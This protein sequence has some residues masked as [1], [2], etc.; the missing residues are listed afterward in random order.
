MPLLQGH[1]S[2]HFLIKLLA[3]YLVNNRVIRHVLADLI[4]SGFISNDMVII[5]GLPIWK[6]L[7]PMPALPTT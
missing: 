4:E 5:I 2:W 7:I 6:G 1:T 3:I